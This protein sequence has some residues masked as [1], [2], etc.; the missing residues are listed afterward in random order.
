MRRVV[1]EVISYVA[2]DMKIAFYVGIDPTKRMRQID[3]SR[4]IAQGTMMLKYRFVNV[5]PE[6]NSEEIC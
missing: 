6:A 3:L 4:K 5:F 2:N 1:R